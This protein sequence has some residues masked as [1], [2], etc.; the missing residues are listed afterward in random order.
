MGHVTNYEKMLN[1]G[2]FE[3]VS[4]FENW[5]PTEGCMCPKKKFKKKIC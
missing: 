3:S 2:L 4:T 5:L 1:F